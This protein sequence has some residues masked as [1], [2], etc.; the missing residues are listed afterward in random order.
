MGTPIA[1]FYRLKPDAPDDAVE[2]LSKEL[3]VPLLEKLFADG[4]L[5]EYEV[6]TQAIHTEAPGTFVIVYLRLTR[7]AWIRSTRRYG[8]PS[9]PTRWVEWRLIPWWPSP[10]T[11]MN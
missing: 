7:T 10:R 3:I 9:S 8:R 5:H 6:D 4:T 2:T 11:T 1:A